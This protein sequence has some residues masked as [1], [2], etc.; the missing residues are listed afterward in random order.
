M[1]QLEVFH[2][3]NLEL[4]N[5]FVDVLKH[6][7]EI[8]AQEKEIRSQLEKKFEE[9]GIKSFECDLLKITRVAPTTTTSVDLKMFANAEPDNYAELVADYPKVTHRAGYITIKVK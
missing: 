4:M 2:E 7:K 1:N 5:Q 3:K 8:E 9:S 6:K